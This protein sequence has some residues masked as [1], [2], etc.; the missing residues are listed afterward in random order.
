MQ[1][2]LLLCKSAGLGIT[3]I[4]PKN[5][6]DEFL[7][8]NIPTRVKMQEIVCKYRPSFKNLSNGQSEVIN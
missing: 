2:I 7:N 3:P 6:F 4:H 1:S 5:P 8:N